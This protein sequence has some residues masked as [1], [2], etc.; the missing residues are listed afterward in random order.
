MQTFLA[1]FLLNNIYACGN[2]V[3]LFQIWDGTERAFL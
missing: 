1:Y 3:A 2:I